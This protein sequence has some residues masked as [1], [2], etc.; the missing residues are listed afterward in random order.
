MFTEADFILINE[1]IVIQGQVQFAP[2]LVTVTFC[3]A[4]KGS[5]WQT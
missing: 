4:L 2:T 3:N 1:R 5:L